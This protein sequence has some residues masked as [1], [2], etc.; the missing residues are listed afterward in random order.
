MA[1][2]SHAYTLFHGG[3]AIYLYINNLH[4]SRPPKRERDRQEQKG[5]TP[6]RQL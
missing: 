6:D 1:V 2:F 4:S 3:L 5:R